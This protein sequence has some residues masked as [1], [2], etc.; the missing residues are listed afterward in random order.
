MTLYHWDL[1]QELEDIGGWTNPKMVDYF[2]KY[3][4]AAF[5]YFDSVKYWVTFDEPRQV[6]RG[7]YGEGTLAPQIALDGIADY[8]CSYVVIK[9]HAA[10]YNLYQEE[11]SNLEGIL[12]NSHNPT[13]TYVP[14]K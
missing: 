4:R 1:P 2:V 9:A 6:C 14:S 8:L 11:F 5:Q 7:G 3:A 10:V 13:N 12:L